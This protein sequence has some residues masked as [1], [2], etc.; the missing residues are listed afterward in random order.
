MKGKQIT[1]VEMIDRGNK[2]IQPIK[3][4][5][6]FTIDNDDVKY[7]IETKGFRTETFNMRYKT[8]QEVH[9]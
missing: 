8:I 7:I 1:K 9:N 3:Y 6:D 2:K 4:T 5:P